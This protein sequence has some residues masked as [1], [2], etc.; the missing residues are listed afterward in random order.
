MAK[1]V[2]NTQKLGAKL[3]QMLPL[4]IYSIKAKTFLVSM[5]MKSV[6]GYFWL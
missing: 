6:A 3:V 1:G 5:E 2:Q 4:K